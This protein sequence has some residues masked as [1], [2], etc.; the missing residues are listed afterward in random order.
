MAN[1]TRRK[2]IL[3][4]ERQDAEGISRKKWKFVISAKWFVIIKLSLIISI[5]ILYFVYSPL[6]ILV[7]LAY[8]GLFF[9]AIMAEHSINKSVIRSNHI[10]ISKFDSA[11]A[12]IVIVIALAGSI[13]SST[14]KSQPPS[15]EGMN[16]SEISQA[17]ND[18]GFEDLRVKMKWNRFLSGVKNF[19]SLLTGERSVF[20]VKKEFNFGMME[21]PKDFV[22]DKD[23]LPDF[24]FK[25]FDPSKFGAPPDGFEFSINDLPIKYVASSTLSTINT[26]LIF[27]VVGFGLLSLLLLW[28]K[29]KRFEAEMN[30]V[31]LDEAMMLLSDEELDKIL[32]FGEDVEAEEISKAEIDEKIAEVNMQDKEAS[33]CSDTSVNMGDIIDEKIELLDDNDDTSVF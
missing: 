8:V 31:V 9:L 15:F 23:S 14:S 21:P 18:D 24:D 10:T 20:R 26:V 5:P 27:S 2:R 1:K 25:D 17:F 33:D 4:K 19:G 30:E 29:Q 16:R 13:M 6:L 3:E 12:L 11:V 22:A 7:M 32:S 28:V